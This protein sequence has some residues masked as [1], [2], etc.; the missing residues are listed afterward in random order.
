MTVKDTVQ[1][2]LEENRSKKGEDQGSTTSPSDVK[3]IQAFEL[4]LDSAGKRPTM[5]SAS[6]SER[7]HHSETYISDD[8]TTSYDER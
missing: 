6:K 2:K 3:N 1:K 7:V 5:G 8:E 4:A